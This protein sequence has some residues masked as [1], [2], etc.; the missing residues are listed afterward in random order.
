MFQPSSS[1]PPA[2]AR[3][4]RKFRQL[5]RRAALLLAAGELRG[6]LF[7][8][9]FQTEAAQAVLYL[10]AAFG[11]R[12]GANAA[13]DILHD[14]HVRKQRILLKEVPDPPLLRGQV[15]A[16]FAVKERLAVQHDAAAV[17]C[18]DPGDALERD[19]LAAA[20][21]AEQR[22][23]PAG[24]FKLRVQGEGA[25]LLFNIDQK[26]HAAPLLPRPAARR[27]FFSSIFTISRITAE[28]AILIST[29]F[30]ASASLL[31]CQICYR[32]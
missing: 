23:D 25:Q 6:I 13:E 21:G 19:A 14:G 20:G 5:V 18:H 22:H 2:Q 30:S 29:H 7:L 9:S 32:C 1:I 26:A 12:T 17:R 3:A 27:F 10:P 28:M 15:D 24:G 8:Q 4:G 11:L 16:R 31:I